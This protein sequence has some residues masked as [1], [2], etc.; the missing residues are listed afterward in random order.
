[1]IPSCWRGIAARTRTVFL[2][3]LRYHNNQYRKRR[4]HQC[5]STGAIVTNSNVLLGESELRVDETVSLAN[6]QIVRTGSL[7][8]DVTIT[9]GVTGDTA[10]AGQDFVGGFGTVTMPSGVASITVPVTVLNDT[11]AEPTEIFVFSIVTVTGA[12]LWAPRPERISTLD[13]ETPAPP[14]P[15]EPPLVSNYNVQEQHIVEGL[16]QPIKIQF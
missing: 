3:L 11:L 6:I 15:L 5:F 8:N 14:P 16:D 13:D 4:L 2:L 7:D 9:Y 1:M 10:T 12:P